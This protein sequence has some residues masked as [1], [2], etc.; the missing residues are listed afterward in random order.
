MQND[1]NE[2][3]GV[4][5]IQGRIQ[6]IMGRFAACENGAT[7][8]EYGLICGLMF[9]VIVASVQGVGSATNNLHTKVSN[10]LQ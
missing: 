5:R 4:N 7:A 1:P 2:S 6:A 9:L 8:I 10:S 3:R